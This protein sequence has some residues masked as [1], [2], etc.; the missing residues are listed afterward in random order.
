MKVVPV[1]VEYPSLLVNKYLKDFAAVEPLFAYHPY[2]TASFADRCEAIRRDYHTDRAELVRILTGYNERLPGGAKAGE[3]LRK[4]A[5]PGTVAVVTGQQAGVCTGPL[6]TIY[7]AVTAI[8]LASAV[9]RELGREVV[10]L[11]WVAAEDHDYAEIDHLDL[12]NREQELVRLKLDESPAGKYS[13]GH[14]PVTGA[15][16][17]LLDQLAAATNPSEWKEEMVSKLRE[18]AEGSGNLADW[19]AAVMSWLF[20]SYGLVLVNPLDHRLR[21]LGSKIFEAFLAKTDLVN[22]GLQAGMDRVRAL[23]VE[24]Q[25]QKPAGEVH[26]FL[27]LDGERLP[28]SRTGDVYTVRGRKRKWSPG[29]L[30]EI[31][32]NNPELLSP[33]VVLRPV[34]Q[35]FLLPILAYIAGP[36]E[37]SYYAL[38]RDIYPLFDQVMPVIYPR[39]NL[40]ILE[41]TV[42]RHLDRYGIEFTA[43]E[44]GLAAKLQEHLAARDR[45]GLDG[46]FDNFSAELTKSFQDLLNQVAAVDPELNRH[47]A[48]SLHRMLYQAAHF[49][50]KAHRYHRKSCDL[51]IRRFRQVENQ[52]FPRHSWQERVFNIFPYL[53]K[54]GPGLLDNLVAAPLLGD[55]E[56]K[57]IYL[58]D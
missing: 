16:F 10:P 8:Q 27:Y 34:W 38:Y 28:L 49:R 19:F 21:K 17:R 5:D 29:E 54:Y 3:N 2:Q 24:P 22:A 51:V 39:A 15:V 53:F 37:I 6:Y 33:N 25:V 11:F 40:T 23:G 56:H 50:Q 45:L 35:D 46:L 7:K 1:S 9:A 14:L 18:L 41:R 36:G 12:V 42:A 48:E 13:V 44:A 55:R 47:G 58:G 30:A 43:G 57:L 20:R 52:L 31:A 32:G 4:L 26:L